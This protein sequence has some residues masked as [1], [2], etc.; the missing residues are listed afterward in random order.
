MNN[1]NLLLL[2]KK[3][4]CLVKCLGNNID[5]CLCDCKNVKVVVLSSSRKEFDGHAWNF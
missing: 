2:V 3:I 1:Y 5:L 4:G